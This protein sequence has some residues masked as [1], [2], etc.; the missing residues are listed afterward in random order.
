MQDSEISRFLQGMETGEPCYEKDLHSHKIIR[1]HREE[2]ESYISRQQDEHFNLDEVKRARN[3]RKLVEKNSRKPKRFVINDET[4]YRRSFRMDPNPKLQ[5]SSPALH[6]L[7]RVTSPIV[8]I[9][10]V[11]GIIYGGYRF[12]KVLESS[13]GQHLMNLQT[14]IEAYGSR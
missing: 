5:R 14:W 2:I 3:L 10:A 6:Y 9:A 4:T 13:V 12:A 8:A 1:D 11:G 7:L